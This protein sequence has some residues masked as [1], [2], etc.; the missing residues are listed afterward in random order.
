MGK[1]HAYR[2]MDS[3]TVYESLKSVQLDTLP[4]NEAQARPLTMLGTKQLQQEAWEKVLE[5]SKGKVT[6]KQVKKVVGDMVPKNKKESKQLSQPE[7]WRYAEMQLG[8]IVEYMKAN[9]KM[10]ADI[11]PEVKTKIES[12]I[13]LLN[14]YKDAV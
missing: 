7:A 5:I 3:S 11:S 14:I 8:K 10:S 1:R 12:H 13:S 6:A 9:C 2:L 4:V